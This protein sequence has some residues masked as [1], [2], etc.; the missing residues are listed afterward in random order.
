MGK[1]SVKNY[2]HVSLLFA[3]S[4]VFQKLANNRIADHLVKCGLFSD[5]LYGVRSLQSIADLLTV[6]SDRNPRDFTRSGT[7]QAVALDIPKTYNKVW[8]VCG[9]FSQT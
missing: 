1:V 2:C 6:L 8:F 4:K 7:T 9:S 3:V 5:F